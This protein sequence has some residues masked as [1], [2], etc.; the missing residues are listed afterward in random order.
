MPLREAKQALRGRPPVLNLPLEHDAS[1]G[2]LQGS[3]R[4]HNVRLSMTVS[5]LAGFTAAG[6][7]VI[8]TSKGI[9]P[10]PTPDMLYFN[11]FREACLQCL[12]PSCASTTLSRH[13][14]AR[15]L[16]PYLHR[17]ACAPMIIRIMCLPIKKIHTHAQACAPR[18]TTFCNCRPRSSHCRH[19]LGSLCHGELL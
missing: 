18:D 4:A 7:G 3:C 1:K 5:W 15:R 12:P 2:Q 14:T 10:D 13:L 17:C 16:P 9:S 19:L 8:G 11:P 6:P